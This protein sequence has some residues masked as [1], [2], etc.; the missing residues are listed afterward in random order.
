MV[1]P[2]SVGG[3]GIATIGMRGRPF[4]QED[5]HILPLTEDP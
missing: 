1:T 4:E 3:Q 2:E 5:S